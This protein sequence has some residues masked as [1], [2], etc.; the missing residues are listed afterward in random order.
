MVL[1]RDGT[2]VE[3][4]VTPARGCV[5]GIAATRIGVVLEPEPLP[6]TSAVA[7]G[8]RQVGV[9]SFESVRSLARVFGPEGVGRIASLLFTDAE[10]DI[11]DPASVVGI[12]QQVGAVGQQGAW[13]TLVLFLGY[14]TVFIGLLNLVPLPPFDGGHL[15]ML[16]LEKLRGR[17]VDMRRAVPVAVAVMAFLVT[18]VV[19]TV[20]VDITKPLPSP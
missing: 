16:G 20:I 18:F 8:A 11:E 3:T 7:Y 6:L 12:G 9:M 4:A 13:A 5:G 15:L 14:V 17:P 10:R 1:L 19:A 2:R